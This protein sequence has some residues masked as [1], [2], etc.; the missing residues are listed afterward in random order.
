MTNQIIFSGISYDYAPRMRSSKEFLHNNCASKKNIYYGIG[1]QI[2]PEILDK[3]LNSSETVALI[4]DN[5]ITA[6]LTNKQYVINI[7]PEYYGIH[8]MNFD[9]SL[10]PDPEKLYNCLINRICPVRQSWLYKLHE[11]GLDQGFVSF[12]VDHRSLPCHTIDDKLKIFDQLHN[13]YNQYNTLFSQQYIETRPLI[14]F[15]NFDQTNQIE[16]VISRSLISI[17]IETYFANN[18][19]IALSEKTF[20]ALQL[21]RPF[22]LFA[23]MNTISYLQEIGFKIIDDI[24]NHDYDKHKSWIDRQSAIL[25][26]L[27]QV[28]FSCDYKIPSKWIDI[29]LH[30]QQL[31]KAWE[32]NW[33]TKLSNSVEL[34]KS[35]VRD[36]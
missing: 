31:L 27:N 1:D 21:P 10:L 14:P 8:T 33:N 17:V 20:R 12:L 25:E 24:V 4:T 30:N 5:K 34:A 13:Q 15:C 16:N 22:L 9:P 18:L 3:F 2:A 26:Q 7:A 32:K 36:V 19:A 11:L 23:P 28:K 6:D 35:I 29:A